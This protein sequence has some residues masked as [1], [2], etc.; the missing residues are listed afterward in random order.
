MA[1]NHTRVYSRQQRTANSHQRGITRRNNVLGPTPSP[2]QRRGPGTGPVSRQ[3]QPRSTSRHG[4][5][6]GVGHLG[7]ATQRSSYGHIGSKKIKLDDIP[8]GAA[9]AVSNRP[10]PPVE[11]EVRACPAPPSH[12]VAVAAGLVP[13]QLTA[14]TL[15]SWMG[16][17]PDKGM[18]K[19]DI[20]ERM[21]FIANHWIDQLQ[22]E[23]LACESRD[24]RWRS[25]CAT[26]SEAAAATE[27]DTIP[28]HSTAPT[29]RRISTPGISTPTK[30]S[31]VAATVTTTSIT[32]PSTSKKPYS[33]TSA[34]ATGTVPGPT[35]G[36]GRD[37]GVV[38]SPRG[39]DSKLPLR[40]QSMTRP[41]SSTPI[42]KVCG[43]GSPMP[44]S[45]ATRYPP[46]S[47]NIVLDRIKKFSN[48][49][50]VSLVQLLEY[51]RA[52]PGIELLSGIID[53]LSSSFS[54]YTRAG[55]YFSL[56]GT[57]TADSTP[58]P[59]NVST[60]AYVAARQRSAKPLSSISKAAAQ[61]QVLATI[62][63]NGG[64]TVESL[65]SS[66]QSKLQVDGKFQVAPDV[67]RSCIA[68]LQV[69]GAIFQNNGKLFPL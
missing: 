4:Q 62:N 65:I 39:S 44:H 51:F 58:N 28:Q 64:M 66:V 26:D 57:S 40:L 7:R 11:I 25:L 21:Q 3:A 18:S 27:S 42:E 53:V 19:S 54:I 5:G 32:P 49:T 45:K 36:P 63:A 10:P 12:A 15:L 31:A 29:H 69:Q 34:T 33:R 13:E 24:G 37:A 16:E 59:L 2:A 38:M 1:T 61:S 47:Q 55:K 8:Y 68:D 23:Y 30:V 50:G 20:Y 46:L 67:L 48:T 17:M 52:Y 9:T 22:E 35:P 56:D 14:D 6:P 60:S 41:A 43:T